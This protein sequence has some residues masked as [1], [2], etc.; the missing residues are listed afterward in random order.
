L[1]ADSSDNNATTTKDA[2]DKKSKSVWVELD[3]TAVLMELSKSLWESP[4][5]NSKLSDK[6]QQ[7]LL[8]KQEV[9]DSAVSPMKNG[10]KKK[11]NAKVNANRNENIDNI[12]N[13]GRTSR[14]EQQLLL[15]HAKSASQYGD[16]FHTLYITPVYSDSQTP[17]SNTAASMMQEKQQQRNQQHKKPQQRKLILNKSSSASFATKGRPYVHKSQ[18][19]PPN[20]DNDVEMDMDI[21]FDNED[22]ADDDNKSDQSHDKSGKSVDD[23]KLGKNSKAKRKSTS[24]NDTK[25]PTKQP[26]RSNSNSFDKPNKAAP[27]RKKVDAKRNQRSSNG[28]IVVSPLSVPSEPA[29]RKPLKSAT[30]TGLGFTTAY[31]GTVAI[32]TKPYRGGPKDAPK[33]ARTPLPKMKK[34]EK[35]SSK[36]TTTD[37]LGLP[38]GVTM[39]PSGKWVR[40]NWIFACVY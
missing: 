4:L 38:R 37:E 7:M 1:D 27:K 33:P 16:Y 28:T 22:H 12:E 26:K 24:S 17:S 8:A 30:S 32:K 11:D 34:S 36:Q 19:L 23:S 25:K 35:R 40:S 2:G 9:A 10:D 6:Q 31:G 18:D 15:Q 21:H 14:H 20:G 13:G 29:R 3:E 39:R 5:E